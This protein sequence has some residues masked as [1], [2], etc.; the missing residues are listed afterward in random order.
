MD[1]KFHTRERRK[2]GD[3][4]GKKGGKQAG[5]SKLSAALEQ[6]EVHLHPT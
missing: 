3:G 4:G 1:L 2:D 5:G 6:V